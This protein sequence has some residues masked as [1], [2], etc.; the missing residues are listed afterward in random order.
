MNFH[1]LKPKGVV[2]FPHLSFLND[3]SASY[4]TVFATRLTQEMHTG[5]I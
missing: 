5:T 1:F 4:F 2:Y 3:I